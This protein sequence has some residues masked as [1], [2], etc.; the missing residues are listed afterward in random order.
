MMFVEGTVQGRG[1]LQDN[2]LPRA[3]MDAPIHS[4]RSLGKLFRA[5]APANS[6]VKT[7]MVFL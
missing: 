2:S 3:F 7:A 1:I 4:E 5:S 6:T